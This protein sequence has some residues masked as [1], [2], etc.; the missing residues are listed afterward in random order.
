[1]NRKLEILGD[2]LG[3]AI[4]TL[5]PFGALIMGHGLGY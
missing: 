5:A 3:A 1:M 2:I 4:V